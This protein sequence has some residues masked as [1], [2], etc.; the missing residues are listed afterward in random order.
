MFT[1]S[2]ILALNIVC[3]FSLLTFGFLLILMLLTFLFKSNGLGFITLVLE[4][5]ALGLFGLFECR[6]GGY[7]VYSY[8]WVP[9]RSHMLVALLVYLGICILTLHISLSIWLFWMG[10][11]SMVTLA[12]P[13]ITYLIY[14]LTLYILR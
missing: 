12:S 10:V 14:P 2:F 7:A 4:R 6:C 9:I 1:H 5:F 13:I 3:N 8:A 11:T